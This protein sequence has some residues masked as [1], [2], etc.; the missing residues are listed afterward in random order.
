MPEIVFH[1]ALKEVI[2]LSN[3]DVSELDLV[4][5]KKQVVVDEQC[6]AAVLRGAHI[7]APGVLG[8]LSCK[9]YDVF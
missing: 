2:L 8:M 6:G 5:R 1:S 3:W 7:F 4:E 9:N